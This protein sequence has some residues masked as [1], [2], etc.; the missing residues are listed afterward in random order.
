MEL[1]AE[2]EALRREVEESKAKAATAEEPV[3]PEDQAVVSEIE[4]LR[5]ELR[6]LRGEGAEESPK[7]TPRTLQFTVGIPVQDSG[8]T[9][10]PYREGTSDVSEA[11]TPTW[12]T[13]WYWCGR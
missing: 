4:A 3:R 6:K 13:A 9:P 5:M 10:S 7:P 8:A 2:A 1:L 12:A 11:A